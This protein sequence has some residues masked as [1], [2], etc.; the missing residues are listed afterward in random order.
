MSLFTRKFT[1]PRWRKRGAAAEEEEN[2]TTTRTQRK[3]E[4][5]NPILFS[6]LGLCN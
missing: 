1:P 6:R 3:E 2:R 5:R 4:E